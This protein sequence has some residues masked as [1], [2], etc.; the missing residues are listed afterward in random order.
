MMNAIGQG[1]T[2]LGKDGTFEFVNFAYAQMLGRLPEQIIGKFPKDFTDP[3]DLAVLSQAYQERLE[4]K[5][6]T[7]E[8]RLVHLSG[9][10][11][12]VQ[13]KS[14]PRSAHVQY[15]GAIAV[16]TNLTEKKRADELL[17]KAHPRQ[18]ALIEHAPD[19]IM[20]TE[21]EKILYVGPAI[22]RMMGYLPEEMLEQLG[23]EFIHPDDLQSLLTTLDR[24][25]SDPTMVIT[26]PVYHHPAL[27]P[28]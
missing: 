15:T 25:T 11:V 5:S 17:Q 10:R 24:L 21:M 2:V 16:I 27:E 22:E 3:Q 12:P 26:Q 7:Y 23:R 13:I 8:T 9:T 20:L 19:G 1:L 14:V 28:P 6:S 18:A 4:G